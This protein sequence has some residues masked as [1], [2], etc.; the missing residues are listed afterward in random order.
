LEDIR[1][2]YRKGTKKAPRKVPKMKGQL[3]D[4]KGKK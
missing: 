3:I 1:E 4:I 2:I